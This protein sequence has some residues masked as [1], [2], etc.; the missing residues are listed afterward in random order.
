VQTTRPKPTAKLENK[1]PSVKKSESARRDTPQERPAE[2]DGNVFYDPRRTH[3]YWSANNAKHKTYDEAIQALADTYNRPPEW[4]KANMGATN[5]LAE[6]HRNLAKPRPV[7]DP[8]T[9]NT[10]EPT[11]KKPPKIEFYN[12]R[13][14]SPYWTSVSTKHKS[15]KEA[16]QAFAK[17]Y[18]RSPEW[19]QEYMGQ[20]NDLAEIHSNLRSR[21]SK[22]S[23]K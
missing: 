9:D 18:N 19:I 15:F 8:T 5:D 12:P 3:Q 2:I 11:G 20:T 16:I 13:R 17:E 4:I 22:E 10:V 1:P 14:S 7:S 6:I 23:S 21:Y